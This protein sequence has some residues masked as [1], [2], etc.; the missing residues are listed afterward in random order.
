MCGSYSALTQRP[1]AQAGVYDAHMPVLSSVR[2]VSMHA[3]ETM[4]VELKDEQGRV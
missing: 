2:V 4:I 3:A 1:I